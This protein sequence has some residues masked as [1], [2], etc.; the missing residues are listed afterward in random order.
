M[1][2]SD[3]LNEHYILRFGLTADFIEAFSALEYSGL[4]LALP[5]IRNYHL[6]I[7]P[8]V[9]SSLSNKALIRQLQEKHELLSMADAQ[10]VLAKKYPVKAAPARS[11]RGSNLAAQVEFLPF[12]LDRFPEN[13]VL[14]ILNTPRDEAVLEKSELPENFCLFRYCKAIKETVIDLHQVNRVFAQADTLLPQHS[15]HPVF[16][17][18]DFRPWLRRTLAFSMRSVHAVTNM[19][20]EEDVGVILSFIETVNPGTTFSLVAAQYGLVF[21]NA[22]VSLHTDRSLIPTRASFHCAWGELY[23]KWLRQRGIEDRKIV[24][25]GNLRFE[26]ER[27]PPRV[28]RK[29]LLDQFHIPESVLL[30]LFTTQPF[31]E[32]VNRT[33]LRWIQES[34]GGLPL[35]VLIKSHHADRLNYQSLAGS[36]RIIAVPDTVQ[37][38]DLL[39]NID[40]IMTVSSNTAIEAAAMGK[41]IVTLQPEIPYHFESNNTDFNSFLARAKAGYTAASPEELRKVLARLCASDK[42]RQNLVRQAEKFINQTLAGGPSSNPSRSM[43]E[44]IQGLLDRPAARGENA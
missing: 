2:G 18:P 17:R 19:V 33:I 15:G 37:L 10:A 13:R 23:R 35:A 41:G 9:D 1:Y 21:V 31:G 40:F 3:R 11:W 42:A 4:T 44:L 27:R 36:G 14:I 25:T 28:D 43:G 30:A 32:E 20:R 34:I 5:V 38:Y 16:G 8:F 24:C 7:R 22:P 12:L 39:P 6:L 29:T 26:Y